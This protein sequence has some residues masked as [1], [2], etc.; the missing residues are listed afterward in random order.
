MTE[1]TG[2]QDEKMEWMGTPDRDEGSP[3]YQDTLARTEEDPNDY[4]PELT[5]QENQEAKTMATDT[6]TANIP[7]V[8]VLGTV[9]TGKVVKPGWA[10]ETH[11]LSDR[12]LNNLSA[13]GIQVIDEPG[14]YVF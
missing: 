8:T 1:A 14:N 5:R 13:L 6:S 12:A 9:P 2:W 3:I 7:V 10:N 4:M 11:V